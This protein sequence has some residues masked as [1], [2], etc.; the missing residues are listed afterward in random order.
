VLGK[1]RCNISFYCLLDTICGE[2]QKKRVL[3]LDITH[4]SIFWSNSN[5]RACMGIFV[6]GS[7][8]LKG[9]TT[10]QMTANWFGDKERTTAT[11]IA[12]FSNLFGGAVAFGLSAMVC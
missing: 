5:A 12:V 3:V 8:W 9:Y 1:H 2:S 6:I 11:S 10:T 7:Q 4:W